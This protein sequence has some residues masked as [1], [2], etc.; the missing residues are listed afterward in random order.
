MKAPGE[1]TEVA[2]GFGEEGESSSAYGSFTS[3][4]ATTPGVVFDHVGI[5]VLRQLLQGGD[6][7]LGGG[8][9]DRYLLHKGESISS[10]VVY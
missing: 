5:S 1:T 2:L 7:V 8:A 3:C 6:G 4:D 9:E 10:V